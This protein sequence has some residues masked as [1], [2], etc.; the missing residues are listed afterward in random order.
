MLSQDSTSP[1]SSDTEIPSSSTLHPHPERIHIPQTV[2][3]NDVSLPRKALKS[4]NLERMGSHQAYQPHNQA[5]F[6][7]HFHY[8]PA[9]QEMVNGHHQSS[10]YASS[11]PRNNLGYNQPI[12]HSISPNT[13]T[14]NV[15]TGQ[16]IDSSSLVSPNNFLNGEVM[17]N[18]SNKS[19][20]RFAAENTEF[21]NTS[22]PNIPG[23]MSM[24]PQGFGN[25]NSNKNQDFS[26]VSHG[27]FV[28]E[29]SKPLPPQ[30][31]FPKTS[32]MNNGRI[33]GF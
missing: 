21:N 12:D 19:Y 32:M 25:H 5:P 17:N 6:Q 16:R 31:D 2:N 20:G 30:N 3:Y 14:Y 13:Y 33:F 4:E 23:Y 27:N 1:S 28:K 15:F 22:N 7:P 11:N 9:H 24:N 18:T 8:K 29:F 10:S 26:F